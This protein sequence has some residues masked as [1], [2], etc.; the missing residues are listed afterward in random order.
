MTMGLDVRIWVEERMIGDTVK[1]L[2]SVLDES[3]L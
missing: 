3:P 2:K 1:E